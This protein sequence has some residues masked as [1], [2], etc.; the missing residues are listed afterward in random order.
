M[1]YIAKVTIRYSNS[2]G[3]LFTLM[4][5]EEFQLEYIEIENENEI[6]MA[7]GKNSQGHDIRIP[8]DVLDQFLAKQ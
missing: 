6:S 7:I 3:S 4:E 8:L 5:G 2:E 1:K